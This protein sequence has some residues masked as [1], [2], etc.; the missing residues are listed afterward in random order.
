MPVVLRFGRFNFYIYPQD[1]GPPHVHIIAADAEA[2]I[3]IEKGRAV[4]VYGFKRKTVKHLE[5]IVTQN[6]EELL[7]AWNEYQKEE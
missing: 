3:N 2:K 5:Q 6:K 7:E 4:A 1:H